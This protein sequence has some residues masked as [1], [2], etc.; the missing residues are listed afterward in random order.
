MM[1]LFPMTWA[2]LHVGVASVA[3]WLLYETHVLDSA[4]MFLIR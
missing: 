1:R 2:A 3:S 4:T